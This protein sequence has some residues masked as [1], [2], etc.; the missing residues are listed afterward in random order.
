[1]ILI[2]GVLRILLTAATL[3][4]AVPQQ[5]QPAAVGMSQDRAPVARRVAATAQLAAQE[6]R[7]GVVDGRVIAKAEV[8]EA[9]L[10]LQEARRSAALLPPAAGAAATADIDVL[11]RLVAATAPADSLDAHVRTLADGLTRRLGVTLDEL[12][13]QTPSL[14]R[15]AEVYQTNC[16]GCHGAVGRGDGPQA[17]GLDPAPAN[18]ADGAAL[19]DVSPL[20]YFRRIGIGT[21][22]TAMPAFEGRLSAE[23]RW[24]AALYASIL[25]M[26][27]P[28]G[29][30]PPSLRAFATTGPMSDDQ[31]LTALG[32]K[33]RSRPEAL[34]RL[35]AVR[36]FQADHTGEATAQV[37]DQVRRQLDSAFALARTGDPAA[38]GR[39]FD[40]YMTFEQVERGVRAKNPGLAAELEGAFA[41]LRTRAAGGATTAELGALRRQLDA[42]LENAE[43]TLGDQPSPFNL[44]VQ[45]FIIMLREGLEAILIVGALMTFL[46]KMGAG[47]RRRDIHIGVGAA[48]AASLAT[49]VVLETIFV[50]SPAR[51]EALEGATMVVATL[52]LFYVSYWLLSKMEVV[53]WNHFVK[54]KV[55][56]ALNSGSALALATA[57]FLAVY[58]EGFETVLFYKAL[59]VAG[60][61][62]GTVP[63]AGGI[64]AGS[65]V[66][67]GVYIAINRFGVRLPLK[68]FFAVTS[69]FLYYMA[70]V[71][72]GKGIAEL[73]EGGFIATTILPWA[74]RVPALG[75]YPTVESLSAQGLLLAL[76]A[77]ALI[78]NFVLEPR[79][80]R[81]VTS[82]MVPEPRPAP[83][84]PVAPAGRARASRDA[85]QPA[86]VVELLRSLERMEADLAEM[87]AE[88]ER[89]RRHLVSESSVPVRRPPR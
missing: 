82:V 5:Q 84:A 72:A 32:V 15:G 81:G 88:V 31:V 37:F 77:V 46:T 86:A 21:V 25:R 22:G 56:D 1:M 67:V 14:A 40:A 33:D 43:R 62:G 35:A 23:D 87:R 85:V 48:V 39:A 38:S 63:V 74:P 80:V 24:A 10:F 47:H 49:A 61:A 58:R 55:Q 7:I 53:K 68:P 8:E 27:P 29:D 51:R 69:A 9:A 34:G 26:P 59:F 3:T 4:P 73:Q 76:A 89:M 18:L 45:S 11:I 57:A 70:F 78:W 65:V 13:A 71:F 28:R 16:A 20:D 66:L 30:V 79:R 44:F 75:V 52:V 36:V 6:Y 83:P 2:G 54:S 17:A 50:L 64:L 42:G 12:P 19:R 60:T 41:S